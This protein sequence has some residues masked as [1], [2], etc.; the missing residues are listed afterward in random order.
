[1]NAQD[2]EVADAVEHA[3][4]GGPLYQLGMKFTGQDELELTTSPHTLPAFQKIIDRHG[5]R[6][7]EIAIMAQLEEAIG[8]DMNLDDFLRWV[9]TTQEQDAC[10]L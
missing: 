10:S 4:K 3:L 1:M 7:Q 9:H 5:M 8:R 6:G 2:E